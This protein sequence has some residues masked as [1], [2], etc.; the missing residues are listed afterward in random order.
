MAIVKTIDLL[1]VLYVKKLGNYDLPTPPKTV[2]DESSLAFF[3]AKS[4]LLL[5]D[6]GAITAAWLSNSSLPRCK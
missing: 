3:V 5:S 6:A 4:W 2:D 1:T